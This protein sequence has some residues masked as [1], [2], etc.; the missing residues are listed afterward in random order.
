MRSPAFWTRGRA[1]TPA[2]LLSPAGWVWQRVSD[3]RRAAARPWTAP[4]PVLCVGNLTAGG[5]GKTPVVL[6]LL[7]RLR[8]RGRRPHALSRGYGGR[9]RGPLQVD[10]ER[11]TAAAVGDEPLLLAAVAPAW[12]ARNRVAGARAAIAAGADCVVLDD[13][14]QNPHL[15]K[16]VS[17]I[18]VDGGAGFGNGRVIPGGPLRETIASGLARADAVVMV[19]ED[20][21]G[22]RARV[23]AAAPRCPVL[24]ARL[25]PADEARWLAGQ[26]VLAFAGIGLPAKFFATLRA[27]GAELVATRSFPDHH[28]YTPDE[29]MTL[30]EAAQAAGALPV[31]TEKDAVRLP[32]AARAMVRTAPV[33]LAFDDEAGLD[34]VLAPLEAVGG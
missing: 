33:T 24:P 20:R 23:E 28:P 2:R 17:L 29:I 1:S 27:L 19:G 26:R 18:V 12:V 8:D 9:E 31:T 14:F 7:A 15:A 6:A 10:P 16:T 22:V 4:V 5:A 13:G 25:E 21:A 32:P 11:H 3:L 34:A 30:C